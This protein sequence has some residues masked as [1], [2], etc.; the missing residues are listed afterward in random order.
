MSSNVNSIETPLAQ[1][2]HLSTQDS[3]AQG[4]VHKNL[5]QK[6]IVDHLKPSNSLIDST[7]P[8]QP[9]AQPIQS[10]GQPIQQ[11]F[12]PLTQ[13]NLKFDKVLSS[14]LKI[15]K[16]NSTTAFEEIKVNSC[17]VI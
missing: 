17:D 15:D 8:I 1:Q 3:G 5:L 13:A 12:Q 6:L 4:N 16:P 2:H 11:S 9:L 10:F 7:Q 14:S